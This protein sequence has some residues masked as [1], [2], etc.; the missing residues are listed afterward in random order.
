MRRDSIFYRLFQQRPTLLFDLIPDRPSDFAAYQFDSIEVKETS[1]RIDGAFLP[2]DNQGLAY[3]CEVQFQKDE[4]L[5]ERL[6][7]EASV[8]FFRHRER[9]RGWRMVAIYPTRSIEQSEIEPFEDDL[10]TGKLRRIYLDELGDLSLLP[11]GVSLMVLTTLSE[12]RAQARARDLLAQP[13]TNTAE[14]RAIIEMITTI[15]A[16]KFTNLTREEVEAML[17]IELQ[18]TGFYKSSKAEGKAEGEQMGETKVILRLLNQRFVGLPEDIQQR[19][20]QL[21]IAQ[22]D[23]LT[24]ALLSFETPEDLIAWLNTHN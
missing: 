1:F 11:V 23:A 3:F 21:S 17:G 16:Y 22:L 5:Y 10:Q 14:S 7:C 20:A 12:D 8:Y 19:I 15:M 9:C 6:A 24:G 18:E 4:L 13:Q 2:P